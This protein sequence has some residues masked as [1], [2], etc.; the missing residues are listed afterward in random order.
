[1]RCDI[2]QNF[3]YMLYN[4]YE[5]GGTNLASPIYAHWDQGKVNVEITYKY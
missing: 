5:I 2:F 1:M 4:A 3:N